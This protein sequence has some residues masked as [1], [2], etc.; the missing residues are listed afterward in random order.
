MR[1][2]FR[3]Y[4]DELNSTRRSTRNKTRDWDRKKNCSY[5][6]LI[7]NYMVAL[8]KMAT[9]LTEEPRLEEKV[10]DA[11]AEVDEEAEELQENGVDSSN[12]KKKKKKK[13]K[14]G[15]L[16]LINQLINQY[17]EGLYVVRDIK[18]VFFS[19]NCFKF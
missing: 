17:L 15:G 9:V 16:H 19:T 1:T 3:N 7:R 4:V 6:I 18:N 11:S 13:K 12:K 14:K 10:D 2:H 5:P 8:S